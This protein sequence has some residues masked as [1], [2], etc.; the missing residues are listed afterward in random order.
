MQLA[1]VPKGRLCHIRMLTH[2]RC[3]D[4]QRL[5]QKSADNLHVNRDV[6]KKHVPNVY[7]E[8][9]YNETINYNIVYKIKEAVYNNFNQKNHRQ[10]LSVRH[11][12]SGIIPQSRNYCRLR[13][14]LIIASSIFC[15]TEFP[16]CLGLVNFEKKHVWSFSETRRVAVQKVEMRFRNVCAIIHV[17]WCFVVQ[18]EMNSFFAAVYGMSTGS[19]TKTL[20]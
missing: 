15:F 17:N 6:C 2:V 1:Y 8:S 11:C 18:A 10:G 7:S 19:L 12:K 4:R 20:I 3:D 9:K 13:I 16:L 5:S 14:I